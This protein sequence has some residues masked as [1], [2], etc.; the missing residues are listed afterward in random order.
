MNIDGLRYVMLASSDIDRSI[1][2]YRD[3]LSLELRQQFNGFAFFD[4]GNA[5][6]VLS[7]E[8]G[9]RLREGAAYP[10]EVV[11]GVPSVARAHEELRKR[12]VAFVKAPRPVTSDAWAASCTDPDGHLVSF[13]GAP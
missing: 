4:C 9:Y 8:L 6:I 1:R 13:Y 11:L 12:G 2:F 5:T 3:T 10:T 7:T